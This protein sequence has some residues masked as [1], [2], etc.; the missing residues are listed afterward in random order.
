MASRDVFPSTKNVTFSSEKVPPTKAHIFNG[1]VQDY[2]TDQRLRPSYEME[3]NIVKPLPLG[4]PAPGRGQLMKGGR[5]WGHVFFSADD[6]ALTKQILG[7]HSP[8]IEDFDVKP[9]LF[10]VEDII[11]LVKPLTADSAALITILL[12]SAQIQVAPIQA[13]LGTLDNKVISSSYHD[14]V[15]QSSYY[16]T[17]IVKLMAFPINK[18]SNEIICKCTSGT[19]AHSLT[20]ELLKSLSNYPWDA[21]VV[22]TFAAF[23][24]NYGE[25]WLIEQ[26]HT[27]NPLAKNVSTLKDLPSPMEHSSDLRK[28]FEAVV[29]LLTATTKMIHCIIEFKELPSLYISRESPEVETATAHIPIAV[30]WIIRSLQA[31]ASVLLNLIG[32]GH[33]YISSTAESWEIS[34]LAY[35][36]SVML[37]HLQKLLQIC[38]EL[39]VRKKFEDSYTAFKKLMETAHIDN[40]KVLKGMIRAPDEQRPLY[41]GSK[42]SNVGSLL[43]PD[44]KRIDGLKAKYVLL[45]ISDLDLPHEEL[46]ILHMIYNQQKMRHEYEVL[47]LPIVNQTNS[48]SQS[49][50][51]QFKEL[52]TYNMP[53]YSVYHPSLIE[54]VAIRYIQEVWKFVHMPMLVVLDPQ[55]KPSNLDALP[56]MWIWGS[57]AFPFAKA[58][59]TTLWSENTW[60]IELL[61]D[62]IDQRI[63]DWEY[64]DYVWYFWVRLWSMWNSKKNTALSMDNDHVMQQI[65]EVLAFDSSDEGW[66]LAIQGDHPD[67]F[68]TVLDEA[69][70]GIHRE[71]HCNHLILPGHAGYIP[72]QVVCSECGK[73]MDNY[74]MYRCYT[75]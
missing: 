16:D 52:K 40:M 1:G 39:I 12:R 36:L 15:T 71:H 56:M 26:L 74:V 24:I 60:N 8:E 23:S 11:H 33:E 51:L 13:H 17:E 5:G 63:P 6:T 62:F 38:K 45:L 72:E 64:Y 9:V 20:M 68:V 3:H 57:L 49:Q 50:E 59:E 18:I 25:F 4:V 48:L 44:K 65:M 69:I 7:T 21:K 53:C 29:D 41:D 47:W 73:I 10:I 46:N 67:K 19:E 43:L 55:G 2:E 14:T 75:D 31:S 22:I 42:R 30:Y 35:K 32:T 34:S 28:K 70:R 66:E 54:Q 61:A 58:R 37:E 27:K